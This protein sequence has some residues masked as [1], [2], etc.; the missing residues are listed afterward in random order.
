MP[1]LLPDPFDR[2]VLKN[3]KPTS[4]FAVP[5]R[6]MNATKVRYALTGLTSGQLPRPRSGIGIGL[7]LQLQHSA[8]PRSGAFSFVLGIFLPLLNIVFSGYRL[9]KSVSH[10]R[11]RLQKE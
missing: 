7:D 8:D 10:F 3:A 1:V 5:A 4:S 9:S 11:C 2:N 6:L